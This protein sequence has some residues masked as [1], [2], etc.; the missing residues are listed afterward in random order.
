M[1]AKPG[2]K[3][4]KAAADEYNAPRKEG[5]TE[6]GAGEG[7]AVQRVR[8]RGAQTM[9][10]ATTCCPAQLAQREGE[11]EEEREGTHCH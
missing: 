3:G 8:E 5:R 4:V 9:T 2:A 10:T 6:S 7:A 1:K 11:R